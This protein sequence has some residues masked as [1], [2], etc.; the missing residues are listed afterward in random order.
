L[1]PGNPTFSQL[2]ESLAMAIPRSPISLS[3]CTLASV[4]ACSGA[5]A[6]TIDV[7]GNVAMLETWFNGNVAFTLSTG[8]SSCNRQ[9]I[10]NVSSAGTKTLYAMLLAAKSKGV[11]VRVYGTDTC[12]AADGGGGSYNSVSYIYLLDS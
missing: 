8:V 9:F 6:G 3:M 10:L 4:L 1:P 12:V 2:Q 5:H 7:T 11:Q